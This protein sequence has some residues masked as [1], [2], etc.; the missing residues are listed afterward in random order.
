MLVLSGIC[1][2]LAICE[3]FS[4]TSAMKKFYLFIMDMGAAI[5]MLSD[6]FANI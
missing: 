1:F 4:N 3:I 2:S 5:L 6:R